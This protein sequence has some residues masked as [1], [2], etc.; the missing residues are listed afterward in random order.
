M[1]SRLANEEKPA[2][3]VMEHLA[4]EE[5]QNAMRTADLIIA[6]GQGNFETMDEIPYPASFLFL[7]KRPVVIQKI[8]AGARSIQVRNI[9]F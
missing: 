2:P 5:F 8:Q 9:N 3:G 4:G 1:K 6:K 7:A